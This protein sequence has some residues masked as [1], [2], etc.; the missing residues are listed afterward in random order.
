M[1]HVTYDI[2][3]LEDGTELGFYQCTDCRT[4]WYDTSDIMPYFVRLRNMV[5]ELGGA[6]VVKGEVIPTNMSKTRPA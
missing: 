4:Q 3:K 2:E 1:K 5:R 6:P